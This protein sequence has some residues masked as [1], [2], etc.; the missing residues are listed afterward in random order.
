MGIWQKYTIEKIT[1]KG[2]EAEILIGLGNTM[3]EASRILEISWQTQNHW[4]R[5]YGSMYII[6]TKKPE[7]MEKE[8]VRLKQ[9]VAD[10]GKWVQIPLKEYTK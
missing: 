10:H 9:L 4:R 1:T 6:Q 3:K 5:E 7:E 8:K 2:R